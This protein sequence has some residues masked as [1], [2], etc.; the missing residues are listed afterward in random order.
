[1]YR[2]K[3]QAEEFDE[4]KYSMLRGHK[5]QKLID[6]T[7]E[8]DW[9]KIDN[10]VRTVVGDVLDTFR[11]KL[12]IM[13]KLSS[14]NY[15]NIQVF[16]GRIGA[17]EHDCD[18]L[19]RLQEDF[20]AFK[21]SYGKDRLHQKGRENAVS[22]HLTD[23]LAK[24][25]KLDEFEQENKRRVQTALQNMQELKEFMTSTVQQTQILNQESQDLTLKVKQELVDDLRII[26][27]TV[28]A[29]KEASEKMANQCK[30]QATRLEHLDIELMAHKA[31][32]AAAE[33]KSSRAL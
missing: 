25:K 16:R 8:L 22:G 6:D 20:V 26:K 32:G 29:V 4:D 19:N 27:K 28:G 11:G 15:R 9:V 21:E 13:A 10:R 3:A 2:S 23:L 14:S 24:V 5:L 17:L 30:T 12:N 1:V 7:P 33:D 31:R 18:A